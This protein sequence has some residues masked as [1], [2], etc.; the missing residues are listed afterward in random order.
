MTSIEAH[1]LEDRVAIVTGGTSGIGAATARAMAAAGARVV[2]VGRR[3][4]VGEAIAAEIVAI[5]GEAIFHRAD[6]RE[7]AACNL[8][9]EAAVQRWGRLDLAFN[10]AGIFDPP[11][12]IDAYADEAWDAM[13]ASNLTTVFRCMRAELD[14]MKTA[15]GGAIVNNASTV[16]HRGS[17]AGSPGYVVAKH[18]V[19]GLTRQA[20]VQYVDAGIRV[21]AVSPG[22]TRTEMT[23]SATAPPEAVREMLLPLNPRGEYVEAADVAAAVVYLCSD[24]AS[25]ISGQ[26]VVLD[27]GQLAS[28]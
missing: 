13:I 5:G 11:A 7:R 26:D 2:I 3:A 18:G 15:G 28:L 9:V 16:G 1:L 19:L 21:N 6:L 10:N 22:P 12:P 14:A 23:S 8:M 24:A 17:A 20:A 4:E 27:G 25:M